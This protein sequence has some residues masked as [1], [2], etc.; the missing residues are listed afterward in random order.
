[1]PFCERQAN[2]KGIRVLPIKVKSRLELMLCG[3]Y[4]NLS[5]FINIISIWH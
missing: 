2:V 1:M 3:L 5:N 4:Y